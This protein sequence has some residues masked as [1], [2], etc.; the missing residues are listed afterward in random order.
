MSSMDSITNYLPLMP[1]KRKKK[2]RK[3]QIY[4][5]NAMRLELLILIFEFNLTCYNASRILNIPYT[6]CKVIYGIYK[7]EKRI[8]SNARFKKTELHSLSEACLLVNPDLIRADA[9]RKLTQ[10]IINGSI[11]RS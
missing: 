7:K 9:H 8:I 4:V 1:K 11:P 6:N 5:T 3:T 10:A 2:P